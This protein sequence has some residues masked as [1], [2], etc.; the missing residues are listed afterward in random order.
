MRKQT[1]KV[2]LLSLIALCGIVLAFASCSNE[3]VAQSTVDTN[4]EN[5]SNLTSFV[6]GA[7]ATRTSLN[8]DD[9][10]FF[11]EAGDHIYV[12]DDNGTWQKSS[13]APTEKTPS[14]KFMV[15]GKYTNSTTYKVYYP[16]KNGLNNNVTISAAQSQAQPNSTLHIG[17]AGDCGTAD[18]T[19][20]NGVFNFRLDHQA[21]ILVFQPFTSNT[22]VK[23]CQLTKIEVTSD[24]DLTGTY[25]LDTTTGELTGTGSGKTIT[26]TTKGSGS[27]ANGFS[28]NTTTADVK[29]NAAY[30][31]IRP[32]TH[33]LTVRYWIKDY[34]TNVEGAIT[35]TYDSFKYEKND[36][37]D[38]TANINVTDYDGRQ[39]YKWDAKNNY[40]NGHEWN[41]ADP[42]QP[43]LK[44]D[45][46]DNHTQIEGSFYNNSG[47][48]GRRYDAINSCK[49]LPNVNEMATY[50]MKG[51]PHWDGEKLWSAMGHLHKG[52]MWFKT[53]ASISYTY[54][55]DSQ[56]APNGTDMRNNGGSVSNTP[57]QGTP[58]QTYINRYFFVPALGYYSF[59]S[60]TNIGTGGSYWTSSAH[61]DDSNW[62]Y[63]LTFSNSVVT[64]DGPDSSNGS[65]TMKF[66]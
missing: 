47:G 18:A 46:N 59:G 50:V 56:R 54:Y 32:G 1:F 8:Y 33:A 17:E 25:T 45:N 36:Y 48:G 30:V 10:A 11:W 27:Y 39:Y 57:K 38:M 40:W 19:G 42:W 43:V 16:G 58:V 61:P 6:T 15:P 7:A 31:V 53:K 64:L 9:G 28:M 35:K 29:T 44:N 34:V 14:F 49:D 65:Y 55:F 5:N 2:R 22:A 60:F 4:T 3:D 66:E 24:N 41:S 12:K 63:C 13:N 23:N 26:M 37:Y 52:G 62:A 20:G 51:D 21:A